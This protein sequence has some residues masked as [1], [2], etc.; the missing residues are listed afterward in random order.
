LRDVIGHYYGAPSEISNKVWFLQRNRLFQGIP[1]EEIE[2]FPHLFRE[3]D[4]SAGR[5]YGERRRLI[6]LI[7][8]LLV[9]KG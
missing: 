2:K 3:A 7:V 1:K 9:V 8:A 4:Y 5:L 6:V